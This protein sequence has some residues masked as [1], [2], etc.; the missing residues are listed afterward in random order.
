LDAAGVRPAGLARRLGVAGTMVT[1]AARD[2]L[3]D[4]Q[5]D[6]WAIRL[7]IHPLLV[8]G[9]AWVEA[10]DRAPGRPAYARLATALR[11][12]IDRGTYRPGDHLPPAKVI[13]ARWGVA[14]RTATMAVAELRAEGLVVGGG[15]KGSRPLVAVTSD[16]TDAGSARLTMPVVS[17]AQHDRPRA[18]R[19]R[20]DGDDGT[21]PERF[22]SCA[23]GAS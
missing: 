9:W 16:A 7:R 17:G 18:P 20:C 14:T 23:A 11:N 3:S 12:E 15:R 6:T 13:A 22:P 4:V 1:A 2:G 8:W 21:H 19:D 5:A 10:A